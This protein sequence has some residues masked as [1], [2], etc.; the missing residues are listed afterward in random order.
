[1]KIR[2]REEILDNRLQEFNG[3]MRHEYKQ[4]CH[5]AMEEYADLKLSLVHHNENKWLSTDMP[6]DGTKIIRWNKMWKCP[7]CVY[8][9]DRFSGHASCVW[10]TGDHSNSYPEESFLP[11]FWMASLP[12]P[13]L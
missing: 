4:L 6:K 2:T 7:Q 5:E 13:L 11:N 12:E 10:I 3:Y 9:N 8:Y 1:M